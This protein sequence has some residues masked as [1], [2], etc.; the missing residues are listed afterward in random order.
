MFQLPVP[1]GPY[2]VGTSIL[3]LK[4]ASRI[5]D[6]APESG[7]NREL[8]VQLWYPARPSRNRLATYRQ[9][10]ET[11]FVSSYQSVLPTNSRVDAPI[12]N[13][14]KPFPVV[15]FNHAW[16]GRRTNDTF[17]TEEIAS[18]GYV[19]ASIDH[20]YNARSVAFPDGR[21][22][23]GYPPGDI[24]EPEASSPER[25]KG[26]WNKE[27]VKWIAD[28]RFVLDRLKKMNDV[29]GSMWFGRLDTNNVVSIGH[30]FGGAAATAACA[31]DKRIRASI[32][33]DGWYFDAIHARGIDQPLL[34]ITAYSDRIGETPKSDGKIEA[35]LD[36]EDIADMEESLRRFGGYRLSVKG[37]AHG[38]FTDEPLV[39]PLRVLSHRGKIPTR[40]IHDIARAYVVAFL[41]KTLRSEDPE[42]LRT[43]HGQYPEAVLD[44]WPKP[45]GL[46]ITSNSSK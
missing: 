37:A 9:L 42:I 29:S 20:T 10:R 8:M 40:E 30:S 5:E 38:D 2:S 6:A 45:L 24:D 22:V 35:E 17:L 39:S 26:I 43:K 36:T 32:N 7:L 3:Y 41:G 23:H 4:D 15:L 19:V 31:A 1:T 25:L 16:N 12:V 46:S 44:K 18:Q 27:L 11:N 33:M 28:Q 14:G 13:S 34:A 21:T